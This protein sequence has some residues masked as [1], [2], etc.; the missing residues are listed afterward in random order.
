MNTSSKCKQCVKALNKAKSTFDSVTDF[1]EKRVS[2]DAHK[3]SKR[4]RGVCQSIK[5]LSEFGPLKKGLGGVRAVCRKCARRYFEAPEGRAIKLYGSAK[6]R[7]QRKFREFDITLEW[8]KDILTEGKCQITGI[9]FEMSL[10][11]TNFKNQHPFAP[12]IDRLDNS[13]GYTEANCKIIVFSLN[14][15]KSNFNLGDCIK[16]AN[17]LC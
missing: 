13:L 17:A 3:K 5:P 12:S 2:F 4:C 8:V 15:G 6:G 10:S 7:A 11:E 1:A 9:P 16:L 14:A